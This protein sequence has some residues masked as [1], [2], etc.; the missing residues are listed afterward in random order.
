MQKKIDFDFSIRVFR[1]ENSLK[2]KPTIMI[3]TFLRP[4]DR[5]VFKIIFVKLTNFK[6]N[7]SEAEG[8]F[9]KTFARSAG[10]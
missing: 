4:T 5:S 3:W 2:S 7:I 9:L 1:F 6:A 8:D 10:T